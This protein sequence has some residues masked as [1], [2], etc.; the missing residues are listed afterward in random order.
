MQKATGADVAAALVAH[1]EAVVSEAR[2]ARVADD[3][4]VERR[5]D[6]RAGRAGVLSARRSWTS[7]TPPPASS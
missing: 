3:D 5:R 6:E 4:L 7:R 1:V 2:P